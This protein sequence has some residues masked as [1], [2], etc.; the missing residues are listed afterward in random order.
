MP[1]KWCLVI[2]KVYRAAADK[3]GTQ[4][5]SCQIQML[6]LKFHM[7]ATDKQSIYFVTYKIC[8]I[9]LFFLFT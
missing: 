7:A 5:S 4:T 8:F 3:Q 1:Q 6:F 9:L 2:P